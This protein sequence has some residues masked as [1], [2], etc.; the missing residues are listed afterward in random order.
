MIRRVAIVDPNNHAARLELR[1]VAAMLAW[2]RQKLIHFLSG[3]GGNVFG[4]QNK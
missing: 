4:A 2:F 1:D 3:C